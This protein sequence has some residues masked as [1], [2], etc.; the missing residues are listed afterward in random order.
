ML[1]FLEKK[2]NNKTIYLTL[3]ALCA[4]RIQNVHFHKNCKTTLDLP[5]ISNSRIEKNSAIL[6]FSMQS[7]YFNTLLSFSF[8]FL[9]IYIY[10]YKVSGES[11]AFLN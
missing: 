10:T 5:N 6:P 11:K 1:I 3:I 9:T 8:H 2:P 7:N 4:M